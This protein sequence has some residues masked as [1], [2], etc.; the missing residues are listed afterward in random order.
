[1]ATRTEDRRQR[2]DRPS[3]RRSRLVE[4]PPPGSLEADLAAIGR[5][6]SDREWADVPADYF[7]NLD[8]YL[9]GAPKKK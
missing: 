9:Y 3:K 8:H 7:A 1:M 5:T 4:E 2:G 6:V